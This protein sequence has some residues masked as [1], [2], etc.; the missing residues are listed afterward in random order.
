[1]L[2]LLVGI[3][4]YLTVLS[5]EGGTTGFPASIARHIQGHFHLKVRDLYVP[6]LFAAVVFASVGIAREIEAGYVKVMLSHPVRRRD[7]FLAKFLSCFLATLAVV[8]GATFAV[9]FLQ[10][11]SV[12]LYVVSFPFTVFSV[13]VLLVVQTFYVTCVAVAVAVFSKSTALSFIGSFGVLY[14]PD[15]MS[16]IIGVKVLFLPPDS[17]GVLGNF[18]SLGNAPVFWRL[19]D[20]ATFL[21]ATVIPILIGVVLFLVSYLYFTRRFDVV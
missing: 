3:A 6:M 8:G 9:M 14:L 18:L 15:Y 21:G 11:W 5:G 16:R 17:T 20:L 4:V 7:L 1:V 13:L 10:N 12:S 2:E 19:Y